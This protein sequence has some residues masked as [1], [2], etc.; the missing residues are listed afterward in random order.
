MRS[1]FGDATEIIK[2]GKKLPGFFI[3]LKV[4]DT[5]TLHRDG[6]VQSASK[7]P[8]IG[9]GDVINTKKRKV[10]SAPIFRFFF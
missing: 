2:P 9:V 5:P 3:A 1:F 6:G 4:Q 7:I 10:G 8:R